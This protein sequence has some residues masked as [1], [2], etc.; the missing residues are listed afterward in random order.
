[1]VELEEV[2]TVARRKGPP[3][4]LTSNELAAVNKVTK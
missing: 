1:M 2:N 3:S 4:T